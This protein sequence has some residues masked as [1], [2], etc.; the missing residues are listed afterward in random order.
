MA[1]LSLQHNQLFETTKRCTRCGQTKALAQF[2]N[3]S[4]NRKFGPSWCLEC[5]RAWSMRPEIAAKRKANYGN[6]FSKDLSFRASSM[7]R[8]VKHRAIQLSV[9]CDVT[10]EWVETRLRSGKCELT[11]LPFVISNARRE[12]YSPSID[13]VDSAA[14]YLQQN[15][16]VV[17]WGVNAALNN[18]GLEA[19]APVA[20]S[21]IAILDRGRNG[22]DNSGLC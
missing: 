13:R 12:I 8:S 17:I 7:A 11:G 6:R 9:P 3:R 18:W 2:F 19:F 21:L 15:C 1:E 5:H 10:S 16:R 20:R 4:H 22:A 14:G